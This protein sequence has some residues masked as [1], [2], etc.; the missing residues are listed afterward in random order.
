MHLLYSIGFCAIVCSYVGTKVVATRIKKSKQGSKG[1]RG[2]E[3]DG[4]GGGKSLGIML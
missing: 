3:S 1:E 4:S 2:K